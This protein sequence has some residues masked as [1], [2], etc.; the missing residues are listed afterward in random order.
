MGRPAHAEMRRAPELAGSE[1][2]AEM[3][4]PCRRPERPSF[5]IVEPDKLIQKLLEDEE[6]GPASQ[7][8][9]MCH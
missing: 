9:R 3:T 6:E 4:P 5:S 8:M 2:G 1:R 7:P